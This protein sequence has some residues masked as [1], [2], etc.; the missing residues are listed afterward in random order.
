MASG[1]SE[2]GLADLTDVEDSAD[3]AAQLNDPWPKFLDLIDIDR[4]RAWELF[5]AFAWKAIH[6]RPPPAMQTLPKEEREDVI[7]ETLRRFV[8]NDFALL[9]HYENRG[10]PFVKWL[11]V[12][13]KWRSLDVHKASRMKDHEELRE[14]MPDEAPGPD[15]LAERRVMLDEVRLV[16]RDLSV[17]CQALILATAEGHTPKDLMDLFPGEATDN[18]QMS[19]KVRS[20]RLQLVRRIQ[21]AGYRMEDIL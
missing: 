8:E 12:M 18:K 19:D 2:T 13:F 15:E 17:K 10:K 5:Y 20:C 4:A 9:R 14:S 3:L 16:I 1:L 7:A 21:K 6:L 11:W